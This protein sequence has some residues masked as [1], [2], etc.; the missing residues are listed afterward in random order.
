MKTKNYQP[1]TQNVIPDGEGFTALPIF[2]CYLRIA[3]I[4]AHIPAM[5]FR[6]REET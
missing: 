3:Q 1:T 2:F 5:I 4:S 6:E